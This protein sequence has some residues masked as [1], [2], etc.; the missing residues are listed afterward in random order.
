MCETS[1]RNKKK[2]ITYG[3]DKMDGFFDGLLPSEYRMKNGTSGRKHFGFVAQDIKDNLDKHGIATADF[4]GYVADQDANGNP[5]YALRYSEFIALLV[6]Q[7][8]KLKARVARMEGK[9]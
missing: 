3:L 2:D 7:V 4:G 9:K 8:Q 5:I 6:D 1:D